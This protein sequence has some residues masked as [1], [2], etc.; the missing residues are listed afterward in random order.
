MIPG[1]VLPLAA[2]KVGALVYPIT[3]I[4]GLFDGPG[5]GDIRCLTL[6]CVGVLLALVIVADTWVARRR[7]LVRT[8][9][10]ELKHA[11]VV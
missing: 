10:M 8:K 9:S 2:K 11:R 5:Q 6:L 1:R 3:W 7:N 4:I